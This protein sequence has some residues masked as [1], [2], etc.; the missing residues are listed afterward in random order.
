MACVST[1]RCYSSTHYYYD[2]FPF[3]FGEGQTV[4]S[5][6][7][8]LHH[9]APTFSL[10]LRSL[11]ATTFNQTE[12]CQRYILTLSILSVRRKKRGRFSCRAVVYLWRRDVVVVHAI[13]IHQAGVAK[14]KFF[15]LQNSHPPI[16]I[17]GS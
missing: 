15:H 10:S 11:E 6:A 13:T 2:R 3:L 17:W 7:F 8:C 1:K 4:S 9:N 5:L 14:C 12:S 16:R